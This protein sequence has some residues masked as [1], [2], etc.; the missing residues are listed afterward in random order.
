MNGDLMVIYTAK[1][2]DFTINN[3][4]LS[5]KRSVLWGYHGHTMGYTMMKW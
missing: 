3:S 1:W 4:D 5:I 2:C